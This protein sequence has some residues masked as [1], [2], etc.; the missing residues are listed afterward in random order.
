VNIKKIIPKRVKVFLKKNFRV[1][2]YPN[3]KSILK[4]DK[5]LWKEKLESSKKGRRVLFATSTGGHRSGNITES[6]LAASL[7]M[8]GVESDVLLCDHALPGCVL[9]EY[10]YV[11]EAN[12]KKF[13]AEG[14]AGVGLCEGCFSCADRMFNDMGINVHYYS[15][16]VS[17]EKKD[18]ALKISQN[19][20]YEDIKKYK[21]KDYEI[22]EHAMSGALRF[23][24]I[25]DLDGQNH[26]EEIL[27]SYFHASLLTM[28]ATEALINKYNYECIVFFHGIYVPHG[29]IGEVARKNN[30]RVVNWNTAYRQKRFIFTHNDTYHQT[31]Q[32][33]PVENWENIEWNDEL[34]GQIMSYLESRESGS[35]DWQ[36]F[37]E[38]ANPSLDEAIKEIG[39][40]FSKPTI[41][42]LPNVVWDAQ[43]HYK[44]NS[45]KNLIEWTIQTIEYFVKRPDLQ[46]LLRIHPAEIKRYSKSRQPLSTEIENAFS[47]LPSNI[48]IVPADSKVSTYTIMDECDSVLIY[49]TKTG[50]ELTSRG[51]PVVVAG[52]AWIRNKGFTYD[53][54]TP[55]EY[56]KIL[57]TLPLI[58][59]MDEN[60]VSRARKFA[61]HFFYRRGI[62]L[63]FMEKSKDSMT[64][65]LGITN[66]TDLSPKKS[67]GLDVICDGI[68][69]KKPFIYPAEK[70]LEEDI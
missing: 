50:V 12:I 42:L 67:I 37:N 62:Y 57:D 58:N 28:Y 7:V 35:R 10:Q 27:R 2:P 31:L 41:G 63:P 55:D 19:V 18:K 13:I 64:F 36:Q 56:F 5:T 20:L 15:K 11:K 22:G 39:I 1:G 8:R 65:S 16:L 32:Y 45:F 4:K 6:A 61:Y 46:L 49:G 59:R 54:T 44:S 43:L 29:I 23:L 51:I 53:A 30:V 14:P 47:E 40:D 3:W 48:F 9:S 21:Y 60:K 70:Q 17:A 25:G 26:A 34:E 66:V 38:N 68:L 69:N 33:E 24:C 52:E